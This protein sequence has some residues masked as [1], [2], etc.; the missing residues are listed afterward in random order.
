MVAHI[1]VKEAGEWV[2]PDAPPEV[3]EFDDWKA[4]CELIAIAW[5]S[6]HHSAVFVFP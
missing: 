5:G 4:I 3:E 1:Y 2:C 6:A